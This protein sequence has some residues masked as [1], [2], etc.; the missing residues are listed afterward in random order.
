MSL[1]GWRVPTK[2]IHVPAFWVIK[3]Q[4]LIH[5]CQSKKMS[6]Q[7]CRLQP[8]VEE[9]VCLS[10]MWATVWCI[11]LSG[12][13]GTSPAVGTEAKP[14]NWSRILGS[15]NCSPCCLSYRNSLGSVFSLYENPLLPRPPTVRQP[16]CLSASLFL[17]ADIFWDSWIHINKVT[18]SAAAVA[19][20]HQRWGPNFTNK[21]HSS[22]SYISWCH[23]DNYLQ[24][25]HIL[26]TDWHL[27]QCL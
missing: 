12:P 14:T 9:G 8:P 5:S 20:S 2:L 13:S 27:L 25:S 6:S 18:S 23:R 24:N 11:H 4:T 1:A 26:L 21:H 7:P 15:L 22:W 17:S 16:V 3:V 19:L 10:S